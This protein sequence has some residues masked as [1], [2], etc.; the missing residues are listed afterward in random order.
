VKLATGDREFAMTVVQGD[1][2]IVSRVR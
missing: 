2:E 1:V